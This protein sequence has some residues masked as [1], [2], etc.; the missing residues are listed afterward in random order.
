MPVLEEAKP[1][2]ELNTA[3]QQEL[4]SFLA[5]NKTEH[6][7]EYEYGNPAAPFAT[8]KAVPSGNPLVI[9]VRIEHK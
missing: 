4:A 6:K 9:D 3:E 8:L 7:P 5:K 1:G 2:D